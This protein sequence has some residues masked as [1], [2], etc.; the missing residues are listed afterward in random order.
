MIL[1]NIYKEV[2]E[3]I[4]D[5]RQV[6]SGLEEFSPELAAA[7]ATVPDIVYIDLWNGQPEHVSE[8]QPLPSPAVFIG[9][10][11]QDTKDNGILV[12]DV[13]LQI[14]LY[15]FWNAS[16]GTS[17]A[18]V[19][20]EGS[21]NCLNL[22]TA[23]NVLFHGYTGE[24]FSTLRQKGFERMESAGDNHLYRIGFEC[25]VRDYNAQEVYGTAEV[26]DRKIAVSDEP[27]PVRK[28]EDKWYDIH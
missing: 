3:R 18:G 21:L 19:I 16:S 11:T 5:M 9:F 26:A 28:E 17:A 7:L 8:S 6:V 25:L 2:A 4:T 15:V 23:M 14:D 1:S 13:I 24:G 10:S 12:Q 27:I 22:L 20:Q